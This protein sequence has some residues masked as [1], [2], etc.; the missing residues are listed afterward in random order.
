MSVTQDE[1]DGLSDI[2][3]A[4]LGDDDDLDTGDTPDLDD[5]E[6]DDEEEEE[7]QEPKTSEPEQ[8]ASPEPFIPIYQAQPVEDYDGKLAALD[9][10]KR[11]LRTQYQDGDLDLDSYEDQRDQV[12][13]EI[14]ALRESN[15]KAVLAA[16]QAQ[17]V[18]TQRWQWEVQ[19]FLDTHST[20]RS[21]QILYDALDATVKRLGAAH[22]DKP[23]NW[24]LEEAHRQVSERFAAASGRKVAAPAKRT[25]PTLPPNLGDM[26]PAEIA[27]TGGS[28]WAH[29]DRLSGLALEAA[30]A[31]MSPA[32]QDRYLRES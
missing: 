5:S 16:E 13:S 25:K 14:L 17:Q 23:M 29:L 7:A 2:E 3:R 4:A 32:E 9:A 26:P 27:D 6:E 10:R 1:L 18:Q 28:E 24:Y 12:E 22:S 15:L 31:K 20:Y 11:E 21:D 19:R 8:A 30:L